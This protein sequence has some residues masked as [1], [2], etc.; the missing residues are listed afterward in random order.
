MVIGL[1]SEIEV[2]TTV[3]NVSRLQWIK[4]M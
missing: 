1:F 4:A 3:H 2:C